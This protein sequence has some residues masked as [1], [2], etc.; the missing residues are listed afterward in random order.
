MYFILKMEVSSP[1]R[2]VSLIN[3]AMK[4]NSAVPEMLQSYSFILFVSV[5]K[6]TLK[7]DIYMLKFF[8]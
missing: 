7:S 2:T 4:M 1:L 5:P 3:S 8:N 6:C